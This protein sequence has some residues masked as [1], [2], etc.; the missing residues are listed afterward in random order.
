MASRSSGTGITIERAHKWQRDNVPAGVGLVNHL[1][2]KKLSTYCL[3]WLGLKKNNNL[4]FAAAL[5]T[6]FE[7]RENREEAILLKIATEI[8][9]IHFIFISLI[10]FVF[11][12]LFA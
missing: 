7:Q 4:V 12:Y 6:E 10:F 9:F 2:S 8:L 11:L 3:F 1:L 5:Q